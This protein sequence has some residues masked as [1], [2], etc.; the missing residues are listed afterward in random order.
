MS[1]VKETGENQSSLNSSKLKKIDADTSVASISSS[2]DE[3]DES[4]QIQKGEEK[5]QEN[6]EVMLEAQ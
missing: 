5:N 2:D 1:I 6:T 4:C 3:K